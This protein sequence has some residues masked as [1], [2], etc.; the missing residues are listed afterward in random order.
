MNKNLFVLLIAALILVTAFADS[1][2]NQNS[3]T[4]DQE[5]FDNTENDSNEGANMSLEDIMKK[6]EEEVKKVEKSGTGFDMNKGLEQANKNSNGEAIDLEDAIKKAEELAKKAEEEAKNNSEIEDNNNVQ[7]D[8][9]KALEEAMKKAEEAQ[10]KTENK[11]KEAPQD[12]AANPSSGKIIQFAL[13]F[14]A[15]LLAF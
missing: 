12:N 9:K 5:T 13:A 4:D 7:D 8:I 10:K 2:A 6:A 3:A 14:A 1:D 15:I 11:A